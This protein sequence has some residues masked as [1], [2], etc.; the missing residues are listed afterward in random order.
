MVLNYDLT[1][2]YRETNI[3]KD[4]S[5]ISTHESVTEYSDD[6]SNIIIK[7]LTERIKLNLSSNNDS[8]RYKDFSNLFIQS[9]NFSNADLS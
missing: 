2:A 4:H 6:I 9:Q 1:H 5:H 7:V 3:W 8:Y